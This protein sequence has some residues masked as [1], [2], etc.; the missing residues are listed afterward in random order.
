ML[1]VEDTFGGPLR[2]DPAIALLPPPLAPLKPGPV[3]KMQFVIEIAGRR[4]LAATT[5]SILLGSQWQAALGEPKCWVMSPGDQAWRPLMA[6]QDGFYDSL[7]LA[8]DL[9]SPKG[10]LSGASAQNLLSILEGFAEKNSRRALPMPMPDQVDA[11][12]KHWAMVRQNLDIG[13]TL[14]LLAS[15]A[16]IEEREIWRLC[17]ALGLTFGPSGSFDWVAERWEHPLVSVTPLEFDAFSLGAVQ[18]GRA[19]SGVVVG[20]SVARSPVPTE[21]LDEC[22]HV[23]DQFAKKLSCQICDDTPTPIDEAQRTSLKKDLA[24]AMVLFAQAGIKPGSAEAMNLFIEE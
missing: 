5:A 17:V 4:T 15:G 16:Q 12:V 13:F 20:F 1:G 7:A 6:T 23:A 10:H 21:S 11:L 2:L 3:H 19:H 8:W 14:T 18:E 24:Q 22:F 9:I